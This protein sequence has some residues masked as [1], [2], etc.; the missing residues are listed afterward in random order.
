MHT[1]KKKRKRKHIHHIHIVYSL[2]STHAV[3]ILLFPVVFYNVVYAKPN[4]VI[5]F[6]RENCLW[7][8][9]RAISSKL[10]VFVCLFFSGDFYFSSDG[11]RTRGQSWFTRRWQIDLGKCISAH[12]YAGRL[13]GQLVGSTFGQLVGRWISNPFSTC[14]SSLS[15]SSTSFLQPGQRSWFVSCRTSRSCWGVEACRSRRHRRCRQ[16]SSRRS[17]NSFISSRRQRQEQQRHH[18]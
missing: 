8:Q 11:E 3:V 12:C 14:P 2:V 16:R 7:Q 13:V 10:F 5:I 4:E 18:Q 15:V 6:S 17:G 1:H 9:K